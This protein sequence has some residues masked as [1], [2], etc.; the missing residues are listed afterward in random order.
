M[1]TL[2]GTLVGD[3]DGGTQLPVT[4]I[5]D[6]TVLTVTVVSTFTGLF[7]T[8]ITSFKHA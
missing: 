4:L 5:L 3:S 7:K 8:Y 1:N 6:L 2:L